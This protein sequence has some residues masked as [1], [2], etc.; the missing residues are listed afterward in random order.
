MRLANRTSDLDHILL[1][2]CFLGGLKRELKFDVKLFKPKIVHNAIVIAV[3]LDTKISEMRS[4][5]PIAAMN[6]KPQRIRTNHHTIPRTK[7]L[8]IKKLSPTEIQLKRERGE[9]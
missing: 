7:A 6:P 9:C 4:Y 8:P 3:Q 1:K 2:S 5:V